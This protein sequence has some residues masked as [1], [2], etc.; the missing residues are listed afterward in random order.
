[1]RL[2]RE[3]A[4]LSEMALRLGISG[5]FTFWED[6]RRE[7]IAFSGGET[8]LR[9]GEMPAG[10]F[11]LLSGRM[12]IYSLSESGALRQIALADSGRETPAQGG[13]SGMAVLG[14]VEFM[15]REP[16]PNHVESI[17]DTVF[18]RVTY[19][20]EK[21]EE[22]LLLYKFLAHS[23]EWKMSSASS[24]VYAARKPLRARFSDYLQAATD[25]G[26]FR[27]SYLEAAQCLGCSYRQLM[28]VVSEMYRTGELVKQKG[29]ILFFP[30]EKE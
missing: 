20:F 19:D 10:F 6:Y 18:L 9:A 28:R 4:A 11:F 1:M 2:I 21:M 8:V 25:G 15:R 16:A 17:G 13:N 29:A 23:M 5:C 12:R 7:Y 3:T 27:G 24:N 14:D 26:V 30:K 22:D